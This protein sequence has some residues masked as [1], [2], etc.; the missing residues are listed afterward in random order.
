[1]MLLVRLLVAPWYV[2][3]MGNVY[4]ESFGLKFALDGGNE[5]KRK[6][7][8]RHLTLLL[9]EILMHNGPKVFLKSD[10][11]TYLA[12]R[13]WRDSWKRHKTLLSLVSS[14][15]LAAPLLT[16]GIDSGGAGSARAPPEFGMETFHGQW[17]L[18][19]T[20]FQNG[21]LL[22]DILKGWLF[23][24]TFGARLG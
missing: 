24:D 4:I 3:Q 11:E 23:V 22:V 1:M 19:D 10:L 12:V 13:Q 16:S 15:I 21:W 5:G 6:L 14:R 9:Q 7:G 18:M 8:S 20:S 2:H 17:H